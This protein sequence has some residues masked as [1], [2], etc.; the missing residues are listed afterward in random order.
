MATTV[1]ILFDRKGRASKTSN[2]TVEIEVYSQG[3]RHR[4]TTGV[5]VRKDQWH[6]GKVVNHP[7]SLELNAKINSFY[8]RVLRLSSEDGFSIERLTNPNKQPSISFL[9]WM[10]AEIERRKDLR[11]NTIKSHKSALHILQGWGVINS[12]KDL[13]LRNITAFDEYLHSRLKKQSAIHSHHKSLK[14]YINR[15]IIQGL[16]A[17]SPYE[18]VKISRGKTESRKFLS[19]EQR[20]AIESITLTGMAEFVREMFLLSCYTG[21]AY[22]DIIKISKDDIQKNGDSLWLIDKRQKTG[23]Q[24]KLM[25]L[26]EAKAILEKY[27]YNMNRVTNQKANIYLKGIA[28]AA[29]ITENLTMHMGRHTFATWA[30]SKGVAIEVVSKMLAHSD[31]TTTQI[32]AKVL[33]QEVDK[34][35]ELLKKK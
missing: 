26:P 13:T 10:E 2:G 11:P 32:Y 23:T 29:G 20:Q 18:G 21:L 6:Q 8:E 4:F 15:A 27:D 1:K 34:G 5:R 19:E 22:A 24:Y 33:Q 9:D 12:F 31:I 17:K 35:F 25:L 28:A 7:A 30:L 14:V 3:I 16:L